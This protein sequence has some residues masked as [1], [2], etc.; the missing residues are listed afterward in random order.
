MALL[1]FIRQFAQVDAAWFEHEAPLPALRTWLG[2]HLASPL[3]ES[4]MLK[5]P[6]WHAGAPAIAL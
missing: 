1:P 2:L 6:L 4:V 3:F 5:W